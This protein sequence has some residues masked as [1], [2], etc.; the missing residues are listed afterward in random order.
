M[1]EVAYQNKQISDE[2]KEKHIDYLVS[3]REDERYRKEKEN[4]ERFES[5]ISDGFFNG[6]GQSC[7]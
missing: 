2:I 7:R 6:F 5:G 1:D 4:R 3:Q